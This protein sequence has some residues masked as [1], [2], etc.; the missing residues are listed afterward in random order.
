MYFLLYQST[1]ALSIYL[2]PWLNDRTQY[3]SYTDTIPVEIGPRVVFGFSE[4]P[5]QYKFVFVPRNTDVLGLVDSTPVLSSDVPDIPF[6]RSLYN[7]FASPVSTPKLSSSFNLVR[8]IVAL[9][10]S[11]YASFTLYR[12]NGGEVNR[13]GYAAPGLTV[14][15]Y[16]VMSAL[17]IVA[18][19]I[20]PHYPTLYLVRSEIM[21]EAERRR[22]S[23]FQYVVGKIVD[24]PDTKNIVKTGWSEVTGSFKDDDTTLYVSPPAEE[25]EKIEILDS[26]RRTIYVPACPRFRRTDDT[27]TSPLR[28]FTE[29]RP[30]VLE[31]PIYQYLA[32]R[33]SPYRH[34]PIDLSESRTESWPSS[35][36]SYLPL[37]S[38]LQPPSYV[39]TLPNRLRL[40]YSISNCLWRSQQFVSDIRDKLEDM[41]QVTP[42]QPEPSSGDLN[43]FEMGLVT[44]IAGAEL[45]VT[46]ALSNFSGQQS[47]VAQRAWIITWL[48][49]S[50][51]IGISASSSSL[52]LS[53]MRELDDE[54]DEIPTSWRRFSFAYQVLYGAPAIGGFVVVSQMLKAYGICYKFV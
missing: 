44:F 38:Q 21:E 12:T 29:S 52:T 40:L 31:F 48:V 5:D 42:P 30:S 36:F 2:P 7:I 8:G 53:E 43:V 17:N 18:N 16:A 47:T 1:A 24:G 33:R 51:V 46:F 32:R 11:L 6:L 50:L 37:P 27:R 19:L 39:G 41:L 45:F 49:I 54:I 25:D 4:P 9:L 3:W 34:A 23:P 26:S 28:H 20:A 10:Q 22:G 14:L 15:P 35:H 13:Y